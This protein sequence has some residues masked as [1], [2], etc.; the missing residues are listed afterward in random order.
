MIKN[1]FMIFCI[2][3]KLNVILTFFFFILVLILS[4]YTT[5]QKNPFT[6]QKLITFFNS[7]LLFH[8][9]LFIFTFNNIAKA[10]II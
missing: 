6:F 3:R 5:E 8:N 1:G 4:S 2:F 9:I 7:N 10:Y